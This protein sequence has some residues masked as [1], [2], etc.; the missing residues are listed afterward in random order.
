M[1]SVSAACCLQDLLP[2]RSQV[3]TAVSFERR[4]AAS[5]VVASRSS[6]EGTALSAADLEGALIAHVRHLVHLRS[7]SEDCANSDPCPSTF[8]KRYTPPRWA[9]VGLGLKELKAIAEIRVRGF[10]LGLGYCLHSS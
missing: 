3:S 1:C 7:R 9:A 2:S 6:G 4:P 5:A 10:C 8:S